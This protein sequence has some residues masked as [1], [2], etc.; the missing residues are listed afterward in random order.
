MTAANV[1][2]EGYALED[3]SGVPAV[4]AQLPGLLRYLGAAADLRA[5]LQAAL[6]LQVAAG[7][8]HQPQEGNSR[9]ALLWGQY[10]LLQLCVEQRDVDM[11]R[12]SLDGLLTMLGA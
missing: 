2:P 6:M 10:G 9:L 5:R 11:T 12:S 7:G 1:L 4:L 3:F 8:G